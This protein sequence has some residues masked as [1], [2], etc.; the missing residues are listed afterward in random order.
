[1]FAL[2][3]ALLAV[4]IA[5][6]GLPGPANA[7]ALP[8]RRD[9]PTARL[10]PLPL[11]T[12]KREGFKPAKRAIGESRRSKFLKSKKRQNDAQAPFAVKSRRT[13]SPSQPDLASGRPGHVDVTSM[14]NNGT[15]VVDGHLFANMTSKA[16][17]YTLNASRLRNETTPLTLVTYNETHVLLCT[18]D[19]F[20]SSDDDILCATYDTQPSGPQPLELIDW[21]D[22][23]TAHGTLSQVF[24]YNKAS[25]V[26]EP[27]YNTVSGDD[28]D[29]DFERRQDEPIISATLKFVPASP[30]M[31]AEAFVAS[32]S[33]SAATS[34]APS[35]S[36][37]V[38]SISPISN[39]AVAS[40]AVS[41]VVDQAVASSSASVTEQAAASSSMSVSTTT[42]TVY[43]SAASLSPS[44]SSSAS[45]TIS[46]SASASPSATPVDAEAVISSVSASPPSSTLSGLSSSASYSSA[47][48]Q[49]SVTA[50]PEEVAEA[51]FVAARAHGDGASRV[52][53]VI[54]RP[55]ASTSR[56]SA[57]GS[58]PE[59]QAQDLWCFLR[60]CW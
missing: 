28:E 44:A 27:E 32:S 18:P 21:F 38:A 53:S 12:R 58:A 5:S 43:S 50:Q 11:R 1:M 42:V 31:A 46:S 3:A 56:T 55:S 16:P 10:A 13:T 17:S 9:Q 23:M 47:F 14:A 7:V 54:A 36:A 25:N 49:P 52:S 26:L 6:L 45:S 4:S 34:V 30:T 33:A 60:W 41:P 15:Q 29:D 20:E 51:V 37:S 57:S 39:S 48:A 8:V 22:P 40:S 35:S 19:E 24:A 2:N 59:A